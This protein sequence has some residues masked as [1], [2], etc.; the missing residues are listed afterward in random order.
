[1]AYEPKSGWVEVVKTGSPLALKR[2]TLHG[3]RACAE[4]SAALTRAGFEG[5]G[6]PVEVY[7]SVPT[8]YARAARLKDIKACRCAEG[9]SRRSPAVPALKDYG[10]FSA[11]APGTGKG[12]R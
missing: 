5:D 2:Q 3:N 6:T 10:R 8:L 4:T 1:M 9:F 7:L 12:T 11:G